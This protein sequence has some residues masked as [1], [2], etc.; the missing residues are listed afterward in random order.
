MA[1]DFRIMGIIETMEDPMPTGS[2]TEIPNQTAS[3]E[4]P[5]LEVFKNPNPN[6]NYVISHV[7]PEFTA[8][9]PKTGLPDFGTITVDYVADEL[10][11]ELKSLK[12]YFLGYRNMGIFYEAVVNKIL[13]DLV[14]ACEPRFMEVTG[15][16][17]ARGGISSTVTATHRKEGF[18]F[19]P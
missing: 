2:L 1:H 5:A 6:R 14:A 12:Y 16:F 19:E 15:E 11:I 8:V 7:I 13:D 9:C 10:C 4:L 3:V 17:R 18:E